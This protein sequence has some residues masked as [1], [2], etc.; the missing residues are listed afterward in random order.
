MGSLSSNPSRKFSCQGSAGAN[1]LLE[2]YAMQIY[3]GL[4]DCNPDKDSGPCHQYL[5]EKGQK[6]RVH[7][8]FNCCADSRAH[9]GPV[10]K[11]DSGD[12]FLVATAGA[13]LRPYEDPQPSDKWEN[14][15]YA[16]GVIGTKDMI[17]CPHTECGYMDGL[18]TLV[19]ENCKPP[20]R[21]LRRSMELVSHLIDTA[22]TSFRELNDGRKPNRQELLRRTEEEGALY[23]AGNIR[24]YVDKY[25]PEKQITTHCWLYDMRG[26]NILAAQESGR[27][28]PITHLP[29]PTPCTGACEHDKGRL[30][31]M[32]AQY[33]Y[34]EA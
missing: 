17:N 11:P 23:T 22:K 34:S 3:S 19:E 14:I 7:A 13:L 10:F 24:D 5:I 29:T 21:E 1:I 12:I 2:R 8:T 9:A 31:H 16:A 32:P 33:H 20:G 30:R 28:A 15:E 18:V 27:F 6:G 26:G 4:Y 25:H